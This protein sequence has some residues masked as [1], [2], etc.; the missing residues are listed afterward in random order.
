MENRN[1]RS[2]G[3]RRSPSSISHSIRAQLWRVCKG[4]KE[5]AGERKGFDTYHTPKLSML[6]LKLLDSQLFLFS[7]VTRAGSKMRP[8]IFKVEKKY[9]M[10]G[11]DLL[12][13]GA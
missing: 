4:R 2:L 8:A 9:F 1:R 3:G 12:E 5:Q 7:Q 13:E 6:D 10:E 11:A